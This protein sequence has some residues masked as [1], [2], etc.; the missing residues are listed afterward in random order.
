MLRKNSTDKPLI[1]VAIFD[2]DDTLYDCLHQRVEVSHRHAAQVTQKILAQRGIPASVEEIL[3]V[4]MQAFLKDPQLR[5]IDRQVAEH[6]EAMQW[7]EEIS[8]AA[9]HAYFSCPVGELTLFPQTLET[10]R[11]LQQQG[12]RN[13][14]VSYGIESIQ[15]SKVSSLGLDREPSILAVY[16]ADRQKKLTKDV[17]FQKIMDDAQLAPEHFIVVG[18]RC[19][20]EIAAG[21]RLGMHTVRICA[22]EFAALGPKAPEEEPEFEIESVGELLALPFRWGS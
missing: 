19:S 4:R 9:H 21:N 10:L 8:R 6:F 13:F 14:V 20:G 15:R 5:H 7:H 18:D 16:F 22:G 11:R 2:L 12:V 3:R 1:R 17:I